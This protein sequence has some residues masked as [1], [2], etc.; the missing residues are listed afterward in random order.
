VTQDAPYRAERELGQAMGGLIAE[1]EEHGR[2]RIRDLAR[3]LGA[4]TGDD[5]ESP[6]AAAPTPQID[7]RQVPNLALL[8]ALAPTAEGNDNDAA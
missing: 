1:A 7:P 3:S 5:T 2:T 6:A 4:V 8:N